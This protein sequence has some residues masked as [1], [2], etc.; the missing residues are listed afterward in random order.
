M[1]SKF[2]YYNAQAQIYSL[3]SVWVWCFWL[4]ILN[5]QCSSLDI[6]LLDLLGCLIS[7]RLF[8]SSHCSFFV[9]LHALYL[10]EDLEIGCSVSDLFSQMCLNQ[11]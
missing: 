7:F 8:L 10:M 9:P 4:S 2:D 6:F 5:P 1:F 3:L 11:V